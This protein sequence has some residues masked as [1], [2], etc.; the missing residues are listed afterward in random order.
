MSHRDYFYQFGEIRQI[1]MV[2]RQNCSFVSFTTRAATENAADKSYN[3]LILRGRRLKILWG[4]S[5]GGQSKSGNKEE[6]TKLTPVP[7]LPGGM[8]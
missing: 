6:E 7:F 8:L 4:K 2:P 3:K 1:T 5:Q